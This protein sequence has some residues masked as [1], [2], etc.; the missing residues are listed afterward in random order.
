MLQE[1]FGDGVMSQSKPFFC[2]TY[3]S[4]TDE[5]LSTTTSILDD[6]K[7]AKVHEAIFGNIRR[8]VR[9]VCEIVGLLCGT[10]KCILGTVWTWDELLWNLCQDCWA[11]CVSVCRELKQ[12]AREDPNFISNIITGDETWVYGYDPET[13]QQ[14]LQWK[15]PNSLRPKKA[16]QVHSSVQY[17]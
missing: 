10:V 3:A 13:K 14:L 16:R 4:R 2:S 7:T 8:T 17:I 1:A 15:S 6:Q 5:C 12:Q 9:D 11:H